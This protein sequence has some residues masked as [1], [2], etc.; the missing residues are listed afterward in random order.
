MQV[1]EYYP[2]AFSL[3]DYVQVTQFP[4]TLHDE[5]HLLGQ[6]EGFN[7]FEEQLGERQ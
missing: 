2:N 4:S 1:E 5:N 6:W 3:W 7:P